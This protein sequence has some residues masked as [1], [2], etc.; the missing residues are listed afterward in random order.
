MNIPSQAEQF[1]KVKWLIFDFDGVFTDNLVYTSEKGEESIACWRSDGLGLSKV[2]ELGI[3]IWVISTEK[4]PVISRRC[5]KL[6][7][8]CIQ[9]CDNKAAAL[10]QV[11]E[12]QNVSL[13]SA[14]YIGNDIND[15][16]C[17]KIV[18]F[19]IAVADAYPEVIKLADYVTTR[20]GG[21]GAVREVC[22]LVVKYQE[23]DARSS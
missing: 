15:E 22:D 19:P 6:G 1:A 5:E 18:G 12:E 21:R 10:T 13:Q 8:P 16:S 9:G 2:K 4:N 3:P 7:I 23:I 17:L 20:S 14:A 11:L